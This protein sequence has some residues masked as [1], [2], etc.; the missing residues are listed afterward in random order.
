MILVSGSRVLRV[1]IA[2]N[3][4]AARCVPMLYAH[5]GKGRTPGS[6]W[7]CEAGSFACENVR[8]NA[9]IAYRVPV[10]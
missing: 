3:E 5:F 6:N 10:G 9:S 7:N 4:H 1:P 2:W 8:V